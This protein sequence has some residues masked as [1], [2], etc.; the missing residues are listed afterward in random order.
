MYRLDGQHFGDERIFER[1]EHSGLQIEVAQ[2]MIRTANRPD[3][4]A[5]FFDVGRLADKDRA[6]VNFLAA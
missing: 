4:V 6:E 3:V 1:F 5:H 2:V